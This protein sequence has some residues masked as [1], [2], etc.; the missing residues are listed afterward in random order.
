MQRKAFSILVL[1]AI[2]I[3][4]LSLSFQCVNAASNDE[5]AE[6]KVS[7]GSTAREQ[8]SKIAPGPNSAL[9]PADANVSHIES[10][11]QGSAMAVAEPENAGLEQTIYP[12]VQNIHIQIGGDNTPKISFNYP[13][14]KV[15]SVDENLRTWAENITSS[16]EKEM[17]ETFS[18]NGEKTEE[19]VTCEMT[20]I[21]TLEQPSPSV[22]SVV[23]NIYSYTGGA[24]GNLA[25]ICRNYDLKSGKQLDFSNLFK[26]PEKALE[27]MS[28]RSR[29]VLTKILGDEFD[30]EML[31]DG[32]TPDMENFSELTLTPGGITIQFQ[33]YQVGPWSAGPQQVEM[34]LGEL[35]PALPEPS[36]W[37]QAAKTDTSP[38]AAHD[39]APAGDP[40]RKNVSVDKAQ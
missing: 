20:G 17:R 25:I 28:V 19:Y 27:I 35:A 40:D 4:A 11:S 26:N 2:I 22:V 18:P 32:T 23:F 21:Y 14:F 7:S 9:P 39:T 6:T 1:F 33:P 16:F 12:N 15:D 30:E 36:V 3:A 29:E 10:I 24:H 38:S 37:P 13:A 34:S 31:R 8:D 5:A